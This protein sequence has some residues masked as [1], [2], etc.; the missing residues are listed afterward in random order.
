MSADVPGFVPRINRP[1]PG[2][3]LISNSGAPTYAL[4]PFSLDGMFG[5]GAAPTGTASLGCSFVEIS[6]S[7]RGCCT[8]ACVSVGATVATSRI[9]CSNGFTDFGLNCNGAFGA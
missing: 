4:V 5:A 3:P 9:A 2:D 7:V 6:A 8:F 1:C